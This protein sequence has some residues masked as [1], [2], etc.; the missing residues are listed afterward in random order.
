MHSPAKHNKKLKKDKTI[1]ENE[2]VLLKQ[3]YLQ[4]CRD[5][6]TNEQHN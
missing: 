4:D 2:N 6:S 1:Q 5:N 3:A